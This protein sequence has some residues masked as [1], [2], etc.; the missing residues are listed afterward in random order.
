MNEYIYQSKLVLEY[1]A[2]KA[3][4]NL[5]QSEMYLILNQIK[6]CLISWHRVYIFIKLMTDDPE[7]EGFLMSLSRN[8]SDQEKLCNEINHCLKNHSKKNYF[9]HLS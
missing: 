8:V 2:Y 9:K 3:G 1:C 4:I 5:G 6:N 7:Y